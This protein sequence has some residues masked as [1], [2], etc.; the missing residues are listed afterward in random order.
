LSTTTDPNEKDRRP[1]D[2]RVILPEDITDEEL[3]LIEAAE[4]PA[5]FAYLDAELA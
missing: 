4:V 5:E 2:R 1:R 3:A